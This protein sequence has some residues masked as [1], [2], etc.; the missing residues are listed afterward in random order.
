MAFKKGVTFYFTD[1]GKYEEF[2][3]N[4]KKS[5]TTKSKFVLRHLED[6]KNIFDKLN[7][8]C[9]LIAGL[10]NSNPYV[11]CVDAFFSFRQPF[12]LSG[13][14]EPE[15]RKGLLNNIDEKIKIDFVERILENMKC[16]HG[17]YHLIKTMIKITYMRE[18]NDDCDYINASCFCRYGFIKID[19]FL[20]KRY[21]SLYD[22]TSITYQKFFYIFSAPKKT[23]QLA[24]ILESEAS[25]DMIGGFFISV[26]PE[27]KSF[28]KDLSKRGFQEYPGRPLVWL[29]V[30]GVNG[31]QNINRF[32]FEEHKRVDNG[33]FSLIKKSR[34]K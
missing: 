7:K 26:Y 9:E 16:Y 3:E 2:L 27:G 34:M 6:N 20:W 25:G 8:N 15:L 21:N 32:T 33:K 1:E 17:S 12:L 18:R 30:S 5:G 19:E 24:M 11:Q 31:Y 29:K 10:Y 23:K 28:P 22:F 4:H 13:V 14:T